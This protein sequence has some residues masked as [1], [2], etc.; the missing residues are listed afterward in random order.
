MLRNV[1]SLFHPFKLKLSQLTT[2]G[3]ATPKDF[4]AAVSVSSFSIRLV[5]RGLL[6]KIAVH[7]NI[8][9]EIQAQTCNLIIFLCAIF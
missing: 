9:R 1:L 7:K 5:Y 6:L 8:L 3:N 2:D 4:S